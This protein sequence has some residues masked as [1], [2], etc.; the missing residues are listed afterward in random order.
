MK[1]LK[2]SSLLQKFAQKINDPSNVKI[3][4]PESNDRV[5]QASEILSDL[6]MN[7]SQKQDIEN[8]NI[9]S[10]AILKKLK[11][12]KNWPEQDLI[13]YA[14]H[15][16]IKSLLIL[17]EGKVGGVVCGSEL[18][19]AEVIR[20][21]LRIIGLK[22]SVK[23]LSSMFLM[24]SQNGKNFFTFSDCAVIPEPSPE[25]LVE[26]AYQS[27]LMHESILNESPKI[28]FLSFSTNGSADHYRVKNIQKAV[29]IFSKKHPKIEFEGEV[30]VDAALDPVVSKNKIQNSKLKGDANI[31]IFPNLDAGNIGY[32]LVQRFA[33]YFACGPLLLG[34]EKPVNDLSR[35]STVEDIV[36]I[37]ILTAIQSERAKDAN[38]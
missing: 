19:S 4:L 28:A 26:I 36:L 20:G 15:P 17:K 18:S 38:I 30:Q 13:E 24:V 11:F 2:N 5:S 35:G 23:N 32:K 1:H 10:L 3:I 34:L 33:S 27:S 12:A 37:S 21:G 25:Q 8:Y 6:G 22:N 14:N 9:E 16:Y 31:L 7:V 29:K